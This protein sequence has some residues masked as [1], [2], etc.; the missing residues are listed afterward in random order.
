MGRSRAKEKVTT[1]PE[2]VD[3]IRRDLERWRPGLWAEEVDYGATCICGA[4]ERTLAAAKALGPGK[5]EGR[6][7]R[8]PG[9]TVFREGEG[10]GH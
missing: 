8:H 10:D 1:D 4:G 3:K 9:G 7:A 2:V 5:P 6:C